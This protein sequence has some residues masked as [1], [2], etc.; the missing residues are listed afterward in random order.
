L[1]F[2][3]VERLIAAAPP[4]IAAPARPAVAI[5]AAPRAKFATFLHEIRPKQRRVGEAGATLVR[6]G[7]AVTSIVEQSIVTGS[8]LD[9]ENFILVLRY[10]NRLL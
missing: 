1:I 6:V 5:V 7:A 9:R 2:I 10:F 8:G 3:Y 4:T